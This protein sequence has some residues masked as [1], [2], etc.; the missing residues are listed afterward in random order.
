[1]IGVG[2]LSKGIKRATRAVN[3]EP[4]RAQAK[5]PLGD[6]NHVRSEHSIQISPAEYVV[7]IGYASGQDLGRAEVGVGLDFL[8]QKVGKDGLR[9]HDED[10]ATARLARWFLQLL[11]EQPH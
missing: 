2:S 6:A 7:D 11:A 8:Q 3:A 10:G 5:T 4:A 9:H 1:M